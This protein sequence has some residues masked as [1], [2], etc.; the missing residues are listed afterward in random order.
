MLSTKEIGKVKGSVVAILDY[1]HTNKSR[2]LPEDYRQLGNHLQYCLTTLTNMDNVLLADQ[3]SATGVAR[4]LVYNP[5]GTTRFVDAKSLNTT[6]DGWEQQFS[7]GLLQN[8]PCF[9]M[10]PQSVT[11]IP[12][13]RK[14]A[15]H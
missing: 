7:T 11:H 1:L 8:P 14:A 6:G 12:Q 13:I 2:I 10:P 9:I 5:D 15:F 4:T 3:P